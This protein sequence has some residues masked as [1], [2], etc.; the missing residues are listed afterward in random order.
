MIQVWLYD[1]NNVFTESKLV[2]EVAE[3][4]TVIPLLV[5]YVKP[6]FNEELQQWYE[7]ATEEEIQKWQEENK[8]VHQ[9]S[10]MEILKTELEQ[11]QKTIADLEVELLL[12]K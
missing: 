9:P 4:M 6:T 1:K 5:G 8:V 2:Y 7:G 10:E 11:A 3:N 12:S